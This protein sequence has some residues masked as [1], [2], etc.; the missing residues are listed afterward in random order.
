[1]KNL[2]IVAPNWVGD[3]VLATPTLRAIREG[4][5]PDVRIALLIREYL[6][7]V[8]EGAPWFDEAIVWPTGPGGRPI[9]AWR[10]AR[11]LR[12]RGFDA[13]VLMPNSFRSAWTVRLAGIGRRVGYARDGRSVLLTD[14]LKPVKKGGAYAAESMVVYYARL[15]EAIGCPVRDRRLELFTS[16]ADRDA[17]DGLLG[18]VEGDRGGPLFVLNPGGAF[19]PSKYWP[20]ERYGRLG[21]RLL[22]RFGGRLV[23]SGAPRER[24]TI[25]AVAAAMKRPGFPLSE[26]PIP[27]SAVKELVAR[28]DLLVTND[29]GPRHFG[30]AMG[31]PTVTLFGSTDPAWTETHCPHERSVRIEMD[32]SP[33][34]KPVCPLGHHDCMERMTVEQVESAAVELMRSAGKSGH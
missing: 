19:G 2:L 20:A 12:G 4:V 30:L 33:C 1:M 32:C 11:L 24:E 14:R 27:L 8:L 13:A 15:A 18:R 7:Q 23:I 34:Q 25:E 5:G 21:D 10:M 6:G 22:E 16:Q 9:G 17:V 31:T 3:A 26:H 29:T 28:A